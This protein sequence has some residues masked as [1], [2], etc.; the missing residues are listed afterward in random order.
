MYADKTSYFFMNNIFWLE[1]IVII[2][3]NIVI[4]R[5]G[6]NENPILWII[7]AQG[8]I[9][10]LHPELI[11][12]PDTHFTYSFLETHHT[13]S[14]VTETKYEKAWKLRPI[15]HWH[16]AFKSALIWDERKWIDCA[17]NLLTSSAAEILDSPPPYFWTGSQSWHFWG[18]FQ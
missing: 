5:T 12:T 4:I 11:S 2:G 15:F 16:Q 6:S 17:T 1:N 14:T 3:K 8:N 18:A 13:H 7:R 10:T 9:L